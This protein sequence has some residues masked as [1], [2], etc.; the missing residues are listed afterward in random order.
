MTIEEPNRVDAIGIDKRS[1]NVVLTISDHLGWENNSRQHLE[2]LQEK[3]NSYLAFI[4]GGELEVTYPEA[5]GRK[6]TIS[7]LAKCAP[8]NDLIDFLGE[9]REILHEV[10]IDLAFEQLG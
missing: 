1:G 2:Q 6:V 10:N 8:T 7:I 5:V 9:A 4:E 3:I